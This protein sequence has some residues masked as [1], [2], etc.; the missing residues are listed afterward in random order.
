MGEEGLIGSDVFDNYLVEI[1]FPDHKFKLT[2]LPK[3][4]DARNKR[5]R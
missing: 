1:N 4:P 2:E 5:T 3:R